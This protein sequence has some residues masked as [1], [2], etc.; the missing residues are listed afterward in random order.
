[1]SVV[2][3]FATLD[4]CWAEQTLCSAAW[5]GFSRRQPGFSGEPSMRLAAEME[6]DGN[7]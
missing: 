3:E 4:M 6:P 1:M 5:P 2:T 7:R